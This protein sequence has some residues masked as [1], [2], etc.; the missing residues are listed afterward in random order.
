MSYVRTAGFWLS[1][2]LAPLGIVVGAGLPIY[3]DRAQQSANV[4]LVD[5]TGQDY[6]ARLRARIEEDA[7][8]SGPRPC[9]CWR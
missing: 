6:A 8:D 1:L 9:A 4:A 3:M 7:R 5:L 2:A